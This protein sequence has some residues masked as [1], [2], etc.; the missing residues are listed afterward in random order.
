MDFD[1]SKGIYTPISRLFYSKFSYKLKNKIQLQSFLG[2]LNYELDFIPNLITICLPLFKRLRK[3]FTLW[4][5]HNTQ[6]KQ[7]VKRLPCIGIPN[8]KTNLIV[9][10]DASD[11]GFDGILK[12]L[13][14]S[15]NKEQVVRYYSETW[16]P[17]QLNY[18]T[19]KKEMLAI[20]LSITKFQDDLF[21]K[22]FLI[23]ID[24]KIV[25]SVLKKDVKNLVSKHIIARWQSLLSRFDF[26][27]EHI[28]WIKNYIQDFLTWEFL[29]GKNEKE[30]DW[31]YR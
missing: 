10:T 2:C 17:A 14:P 31:S 20:V 23:K 5:F 18:S 26:E 11:L 21:S 4:G 7:I 6:L 1:I 28:E 9:E 15:T 24:C 8:S 29:Q 19:I 27:I 13:L 22:S 30:T 16:F 12:Q 3:D 25:K